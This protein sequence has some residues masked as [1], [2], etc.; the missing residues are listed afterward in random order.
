MEAWYKYD[1]G[2]MIEYSQDFLQIL[3]WSSQLLSLPY[4]SDQ[5]GYQVLNSNKNLFF[6]LTG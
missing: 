1:E 6:F 3:R 4:F 5:M 2:E